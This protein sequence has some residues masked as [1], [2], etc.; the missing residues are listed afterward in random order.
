MEGAGELTD[1]GRYERSKHR[2]HEGLIRRGVH[3]RDGRHGAERDL[4]VAGIFLQPL[5]VLD[6]PLRQHDVIADRAVREFLVDP[7]PVQSGRQVLDV[8][9]EIDDLGMLAPRDGSRDEDAE[10]ANALVHRAPENG[11]GPSSFGGRDVRPAN[12]ER[13]SRRTTS[14]TVVRS[15]EATRADTACKSASM[16]TLITFGKM[17]LRM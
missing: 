15:A 1:L 17:T 8:F 16:R 12:P 4:V 5:K 3:L 2:V 11:P 7:H 10:V 13:S 9:E 14:E 6:S